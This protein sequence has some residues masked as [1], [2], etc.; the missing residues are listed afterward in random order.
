MSDPAKREIWALRSRLVNILRSWT[1]MTWQGLKDWRFKL[2]RWKKN[3]GLEFVFSSVAWVNEAME[4][5]GVFPGIVER[6]EFPTDST[7]VFKL[8]YLESNK[9]PNQTITTKRSLWKRFSYPEQIRIGEDWFLFMQ[10]AAKGVRMKAISTPLL[11]VRRGEN[12][13]GLMNSDLSTIF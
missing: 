11:R 2:L 5:T 8:L 6:G 9:I 3:P 1:T 10:L 4:Q 7:E 12:R 13:K